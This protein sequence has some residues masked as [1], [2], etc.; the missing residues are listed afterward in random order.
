MMQV[1]VK[2]PQLERDDWNRFISEIAVLCEAE[3][4]PCSEQS[5]SLVQAC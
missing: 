4:L 1:H 5:S 2:V 3:K